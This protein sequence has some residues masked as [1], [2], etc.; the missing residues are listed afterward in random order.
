MERGARLRR[1]VWALGPRGRGSRVPGMLRRDIV[2]YARE[3][4]IRGAGFKQ[5]AR[6]TGL[7]RETIRNWLRLPRSDRELIPVAVVPEVVTHEAII[8]VSPRGYRVEGLDVESAAA[9]LRM[10]D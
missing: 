9:L 5:I 3:R 4:Q 8:L 1:R 10:L 2:A 6:E 7:T